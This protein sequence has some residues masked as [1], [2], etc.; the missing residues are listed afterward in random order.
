M[1]QKNNVIT[2]QN[3]YALY[4]KWRILIIIWIWIIFGTWRSGRRCVQKTSGKYYDS[5]FLK[6]KIWLAA[7]R[8]PI[9][10]KTFKTFPENCM[11]HVQNWRYRVG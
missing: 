7:K 10:G 1:K 9:H 3:T 4:V 6:V 8:A 11:N 5:V 2:I